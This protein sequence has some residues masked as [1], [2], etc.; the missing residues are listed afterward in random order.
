M[1][2]ITEAWEVSKNIVSFGSRAHAFHE[3]LQV[4]L[5]NEEGFYVDVVFPFGIK[6]SNMTELKRR[7]EDLPSPS[8]IKQLNACWKEKIKNLNNIVQACNE[9]IVKREELFKRLTEI[10]LAGSTDEVQDPKLILNSMFMTKQQFDEQVEILKGLSAEKF[11]G[12]IEYNEE[13]IDNWLVDYS[14]KNQDIEEAIHGISHDLRDLEGEL[15]NIKIRHEINVAPMKNYI[16]DWF[17][18]TIDKLTK[19]GQ[20][21]TVEMVPITVNEENKRTT[22]SK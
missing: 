21:A 12:I 22:T 11:Y 15:F 19:E 16:E 20:E 6:V 10:D 7:E 8:R 5:K 9:A 3:Y 14:V 4:D 17:K 13:E 1:S 2:L 18:K